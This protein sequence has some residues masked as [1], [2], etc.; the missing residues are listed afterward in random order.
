MK[1][2]K[3]LIIEPSMISEGFPGSKKH[4]CLYLTLLEGCILNGETQNNI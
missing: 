4:V 2:I 3:L 1:T